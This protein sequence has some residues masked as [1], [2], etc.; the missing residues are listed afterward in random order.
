VRMGLR[1]ARAL[2]VEEKTIGALR[3][4]PLVTPGGL[5]AFLLYGNKQMKGVDNFAVPI[6]HRSYS[7]TTA[8]TSSST[9]KS[10]MASRVT[11]TRV[12]AG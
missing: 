6:G 4:A 12:C 2:G 8:V 3:E 7:L 10:R 5:C 1:Y 11:S 9:R